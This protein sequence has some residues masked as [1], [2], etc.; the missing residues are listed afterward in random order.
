MTPR[1]EDYEIEILKQLAEDNGEVYTGID[2]DTLN[3]NT[4]NYYLKFGENFK[5][6]VNCH[7]YECS[8]SKQF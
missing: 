4:L 7:E 8:K 2:S 1:L 6:M 5:K 3:S